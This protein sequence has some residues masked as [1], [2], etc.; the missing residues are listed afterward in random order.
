M[1]GEYAPPD[2]EK[3]LTDHFLK[4]INVEVNY[5]VGM[6]KPKPIFIGGK[7][8]GGLIAT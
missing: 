3:I 5:G 7:S 8:L 2:K 6:L 4:V 1:K